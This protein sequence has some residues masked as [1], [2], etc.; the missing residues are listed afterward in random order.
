IP[1]HRSESNTPVFQR[2]SRQTYFIGFLRSL[3]Q[4]RRSGLAGIIHWASK[5]TSV[6]FAV[7]MAGLLK[8]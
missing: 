3:S 7:L 2:M 4:R 1:L 6:S 5:P 8:D